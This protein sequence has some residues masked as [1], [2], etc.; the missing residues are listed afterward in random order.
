MLFRK[1]KK[2]KNT[3]LNISKDFK[4]FLSNSIFKPQ[5]ITFKQN[6]RNSNTFKQIS[7]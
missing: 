7:Y 6:I 1:E 2:K 4:S 5:N 3:L